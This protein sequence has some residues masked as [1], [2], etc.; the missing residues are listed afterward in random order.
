[1]KILIIE[2]EPDLRNTLKDM[3]EINGYEVLAARD[4]AE[5]VLLAAQ[6]P[7]MIFCD[8]AMPVMDGY[9]TIAAIRRLPDVG[10]VP[11]VFL[12]AKTERSDQRRGMELGADDYITKPFTEQELLRAITARK[13]RQQNVQQR[14]QELVSLRTHEVRAQW[15][16]ELLTPLSALLGCIALMEESVE[17]DD[18]EELRELLS[19]MRL[20][21]NL[22]EQLSRKLIRYFELE[23][24][25]DIPHSQLRQRCSAGEALRE[26]ASK[27]AALFNREPDLELWVNDGTVALHGEHLSYAILEVVRNAFGFSA[28]GSKV[29]VSGRAVA[30][31]YRIEISDQGP[32]LSPEQR[33]QI[34]PFVQFDRAMREQ[35][36][37]GLG[38]AIARMTA[39]I[40]GGRMTLDEGPGGRGL[41]VV[42]ELPLA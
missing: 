25:R 33:A 2:D 16:H 6:G 27:A 26:G 22:Q 19:N 21:A 28:T 5:G 18:R 8:V 20:A 35:Q 1:M 36:G 9:E 23:R 10:E 15:S 7:D 14:L 24:L 42:I 31:Q 41:T 11:F 13:G 29:R 40:G 30:G 34:G 17:T 4:G 39:G 37:L 12:T 38:L 32:G 3:L